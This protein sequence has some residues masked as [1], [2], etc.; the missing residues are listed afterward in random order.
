[1]PPLPQKVGV[2]ILH[3]KCP[4]DEDWTQLEGCPGVKHGNV[5]YV[6]FH[7]SIQIEQRFKLGAAICTL[8]LAPDHY[9]N[10]QLSVDETR[11]TTIPDMIVEFDVIQGS[12]PPCTLRRTK[13]G[14][15][16][17]HE[18]SE[19]PLHNLSSSFSALKLRLPHDFCKPDDGRYKV[20]E[21][22]QIMIQGVTASLQQTPQ[23]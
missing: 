6:V 2:A 3:Y 10:A 7:S 15:D 1:M 18:L 9:R 14:T 20:F 13:P 5:A 19:F 4:G 12:I 8:N 11:S 23:Q 22:L 21:R 16:D 17:M